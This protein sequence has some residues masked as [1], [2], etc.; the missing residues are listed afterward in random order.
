MTQAPSATEEPAGPAPARTVSAAERDA[1]QWVVR[2]T[3]GETTPADRLA[4][5]NWRVRSPKHAAALQSALGLWLGVARGLPAR[6]LRV[7]ASARHWPLLVVAAAALLLILIG[8]N[9]Y[10]YDNI[11]TAGERRGLAFADV[12]PLSPVVEQLAARLE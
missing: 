5:R 11:T 2:L 7:T 1:L 6:P 10:E 8:I 3:S 4:F 12:R 9:T